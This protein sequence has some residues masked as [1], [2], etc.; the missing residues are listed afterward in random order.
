MKKY[1]YSLVTAL[2]LCCGFASCGDDNDDPVINYDTTAAQGSVGTYSGTWSKSANGNETTSTGTVTLAAASTANNTNVTFSCTEFDI[3]A[4]SIANV[5]HASYGYVFNNN[6]STNPLGA[7]FS[8][9]IDED[10]TI[11]LNFQKEV[12]EGRQR[13]IYVFKFIGKK[14]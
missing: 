3:D 7:G 6:V 2:A 13:T 8:G 5:T 14:N 10:G 11:Q 9:R 1:I 4:T 12:R